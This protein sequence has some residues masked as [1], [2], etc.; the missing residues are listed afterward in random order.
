MLIKEYN[1]ES[2]TQFGIECEKLLYKSVSKYQKIKVY[3]SRKYGNIL[4]LD[5]CF[6]LTEKNNDQ[7]HNKCISLIDKNLK[8]INLLIIGG[9][10]YGLI[11]GLFKEQ[12]IKSIRIVEIDNLVVDVCKKFFPSFYKLKK[13]LKNKVDVTIEDGYEWIK[14]NTSLKYDVVIVDCTDPNLIA[15]KLYSTKFYINLCKILKDSGTLIQQSG[16]PY[17]DGEKL[18]KPTIRKLEKYGFKEISLHE[19]NMPIYPL[20][21]WSFIKCKKA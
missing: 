7:Y 14:N 17:L 18:I 13:E 15:E 5:D 2:G 8:D 19:F 21:L 9:G 6:M 3:S 12:N 11:R 20:G 1:K 10:D 4:T 16:S